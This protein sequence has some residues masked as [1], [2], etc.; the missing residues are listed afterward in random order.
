IADSDVA[1]WAKG[2]AFGL[3]L[4]VDVFEPGVDPLAVQGPKADELMSR[5]FGDA[6]AGI[7]FFGF[8]H[9]EFAGHP[10]V[11]ART[12]WSK[13]G[14]FEIY[15]DRA[16]LA[17]PLWDALAE[18]GRDLDVRPGCP[19][20]IERIEG[21]LISYGG[22]AT[23]DDSPLQCRLEQYCHLDAEIDVIGLDALRAERDSGVTRAITGLFLDTDT[24]PPVRTRW[25]VTAGGRR[26][27]DLTSAAV[28]PRFGRGIALAMLDREV[29]EPGTEVVVTSPDGPIAAEVT[30]VPFTETGS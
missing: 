8:A 1:L 9:L 5:V 18:A 28:S 12:G 25:E 11:V 10:M 19:N 17:G 3:G 4:A 13:Q 14:G 22:D 29:W 26:V 15:V 24:L 21:G 20:L 27:G 16:D 2:L 6:V 23:V 7:S 30:A